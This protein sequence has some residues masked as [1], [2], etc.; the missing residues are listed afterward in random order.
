MYVHCL[1][2]KFARFNKQY[3]LTPGLT[4]LGIYAVLVLRVRCAIK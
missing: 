3:I 4:D 1:K 2:L